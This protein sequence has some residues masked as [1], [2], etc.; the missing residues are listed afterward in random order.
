MTEYLPCRHELP[1]LMHN[2]DPGAQMLMHQSCCA[3]FCHIRLHLAELSRLP[4]LPPV[5]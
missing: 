1:H 5:P 3:L 2:L 4:F